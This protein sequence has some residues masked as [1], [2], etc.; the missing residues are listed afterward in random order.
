MR[1]E[2][3]IKLDKYRVSNPVFESDS[4]ANWGA[5]EIDRRG[6]K[7]TVISSGTDET[8]GWEHVSVS[9]RFRTPTW[10]EMCFVKDLFWKD[11]ETVVQFHPP[12]SMYVNNHP[13]CLHLWRPL[14]RDIVLPPIETIGFLTDENENSTD[15]DGEGSLGVRGGEP[16]R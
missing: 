7:L 15:R 8:Y 11:D 2:P 3:N 16:D 1:N 4:G 14:G 9:H 5:F 10:E 13:H 12:K 6:V